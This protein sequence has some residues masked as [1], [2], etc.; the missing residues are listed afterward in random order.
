VAISINTFL[1][2]DHHW[3][4]SDILERDI[5]PS[6]IFMQER[7]VD[8]MGIPKQIALKDVCEDLISDG[9]HLHVVEPVARWPV[10]TID[11]LARLTD[12]LVRHMI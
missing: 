1:A 5:P 10:G 12:Q 11:R 7:P 3:P 2:P 6:F 4:D 8:G 9:A